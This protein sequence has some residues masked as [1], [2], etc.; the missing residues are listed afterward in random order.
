MFYSQ[1]MPEKPTINSPSLLAGLADPFTLPYRPV[2]D[3]T[4]S[5]Y[6]SHYTTAYSVLMASLNTPTLFP[7]SV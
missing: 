3:N 1:G 7:S 4:L 6:H 2:L 5:Y